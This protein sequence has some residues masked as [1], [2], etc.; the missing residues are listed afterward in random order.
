M[1]LRIGILGT[2]GIP[3]NY[4]GFEQISAYL[5]KGLVQL[6]HHVTVYN[7][8]KHP[9]S[10]S[11][12]NG[13]QIIHCYDPEYLIGTA[14]QFIYDFNC[15][16]DA[17]KRNFDIVLFM[18]YTSSSVWGWMNPRNSIII[19]NMDGLEWKRSKYSRPVQHFLRYAEKLAVRYSH[20]HIADSLAIKTYLNHKYQITPTYIPYGAEILTQIDESVYDELHL[21]KEDYFLLIAR[22]EPENNI[23]MILSGFQSSTT[24]KQMVVVGNTDNNYGKYLVHQFRSDKRIRFAGPVFNLAKLHA[25]RSAACVYFHGHSVGG[26]NPSLLEAMASHTFIA[27]H[28]NAFN[29]SILEADATYFDTSEDIREII[30]YNN[31]QHSRR[32]AVQN[33]F[34]KIMSKYNWEH[35]VNRYEHFILSCCNTTIHEQ[36]VAHKRYATK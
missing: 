17:R 26:T 31:E 16:R 11:E 35:I 4:G 32:Q 29:K 10:C 30:M 25:L 21:V 1:K 20:A 23:E 28:N 8:H 18:G 33:N 14:G 9:Y 12:W 36:P 22:M 3:N 19:S 7:S 34:R 24:H 13:V 15:I 6:G 27:A 5:A 2:R